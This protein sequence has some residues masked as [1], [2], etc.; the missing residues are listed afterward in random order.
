M[1]L[2]QQFG[3]RMFPGVVQGAEFH[4]VT[5]H[6]SLSNYISYMQTQADLD[7]LYLFEFNLPRPLLE[8]VNIPEYFERDFLED[9]CQQQLEG[10]AITHHIGSTC[11]DPGMISD[12]P[13]ILQERQWLVIGPRGS[14]S[15]FH[16]DPLGTAAW[17]V[18]LQGKKLWCFC[19]PS[20]DPVDVPPGTCALHEVGVR[21]IYETPGA[22]QWFRKNIITKHLL[23]N[24]HTE[25][26]KKLYWILQNEGDIIFVPH[27]WWHCV[28]NLAD[29]VAYTQNFVNHNNIKSA[30]QELQIH[31]PQISQKMKQFLWSRH[32]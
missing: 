25:T 10:Q 5:V 31:Q 15:H 11:S 26:T 23:R 14:G 16:Y 19:E 4:P 3:D 18:L 2:Q 1:L 7:P 30:M 13:T 32:T 29:S 28:L 12:G 8:I 22:L 17:N 6:M 21:T 20:E 9:L 27:G 24:S